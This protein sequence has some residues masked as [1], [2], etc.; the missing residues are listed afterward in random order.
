LLK[1]LSQGS[2]PE[3]IQEDFEKLFD[4][5]SR[6]QF[7]KNDRKKIVKIKGVQGTA[8]EIVDM[9]TPVMAQG[10]IED[11]LYALESEMQRSV[12]RECRY[13]SH[14]IGSVMTQLSIKEFS[15][16]YIGQ[17]ALLGI[18][19]IWTTDFT[20]ALTRYRQEKSVMNAAG[21]KFVQMLSDLVASCLL[22]LGSKMNRTKFETLVTVHVHQKDFFQEVF[23]LVR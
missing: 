20:D 14:D 23:M 16:K 5:I 22:D 3:S 18:Q 21:K 2:D 9:A 6:V 8:E 15:D 19:I 11:W 17:V 1:I 10:N 4:A 7:D 12:R 13:A